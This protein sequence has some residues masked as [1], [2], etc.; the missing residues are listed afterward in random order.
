VNRDGDVENRA[1]AA[2]NANVGAAVLHNALTG[3]ER[4]TPIVGWR[5]RSH[6]SQR[7]HQLSAFGLPEPEPRARRDRARSRTS[8]TGAFRSP[9][10]A[11]G[12]RPFGPEPRA[13]RAAL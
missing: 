1:T 7:Y 13:R 11:F 12:V 8:R 3:R 6:D 4:S 2:P 10:T 5:A 9:P